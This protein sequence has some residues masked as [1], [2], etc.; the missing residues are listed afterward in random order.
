MLNLCNPQ[1]IAFTQSSAL[2]R[3]FTFNYHKVEAIEFVP[4]ADGGTAFGTD[5]ENLGVAI[6][7]SWEN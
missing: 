3:L 2:T 1:H 5:D 4:G 6:Y 7:L